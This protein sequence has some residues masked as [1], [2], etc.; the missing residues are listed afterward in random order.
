MPV[1]A[2]QFAE[3]QNV[4]VHTVKN[5]LNRGLLPGSKLARDHDNHGVWTWFIPDDAEAPNLRS[6][7]P[8]SEQKT[9][10]EQ[11]PKIEPIGSPDDPLAYIK[12]NH[13]T[14][15]IRHFSQAFG[16]SPAEVRRM[17]DALH[18]EGVLDDDS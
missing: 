9:E 6:G 10:C 12:A 15:S 13:K 5:W 17:Y 14:M 1:T 4:S 3:Q 16:V 2:V 18:V 7:R 11:K 8:K